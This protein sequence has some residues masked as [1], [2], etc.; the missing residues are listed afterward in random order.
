MLGM[1]LKQRAGMV[2]ASLLAV[3]GAATLGANPAR[4]DAYDCVYGRF[5]MWTQEL[6]YGTR[7]SWTDSQLTYGF[8][9]PTGIRGRMESVFNRSR[10]NVEMFQTTNCTA[11]GAYWQVV[12]SPGQAA[13]LTKGSDW[14][15]KPK[16]IG[17]ADKVRYPCDL[18]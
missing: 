16:S 15:H 2:L 3:L 7:Y 13:M 8:T 18:L 10:R 9:L 11:S 14:Y 6:G 5:C 4:A 1:T 17:R 12:M